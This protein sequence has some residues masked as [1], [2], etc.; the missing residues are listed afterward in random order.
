MPDPY[1][2]TV[3]KSELKRDA[4]M[5]KVVGKALKRR[6]RK[7][8][9]GRYSKVAALIPTVT[10]RP[11]TVLTNAQYGADA[12]GGTP[13][14]AADSS[15]GWEDTKSTKVTHTKYS[16]LQKEAKFGAMLKALMRRLGRAKPKSSGFGDRYVPGRGVPAEQ[17]LGYRTTP[18]RPPRPEP[19]GP[20]PM[21]GVKP[22]PVSPEGVIFK[23]NPFVHPP[24]SN[25]P[26][27]V[28]SIGPR[29]R[30]RGQS[31]WSWWERILKK[32]KEGLTDKPS[33]EYSKLLG[34]PQTT[35]LGIGDMAG[36]AAGAVKGTAKN[37]AVQMGAGGAAAAGTAAA[38]SDG[39]IRGM[40]AQHAPGASIM[41]L[42]Q[43]LFASKAQGA[44]PGQ[45][46][47]IGPGGQRL[48]KDQALQQLEPWF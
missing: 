2:T 11:P 16:S 38:L 42:L 13:P 12:W 9:R 6:K 3:A 35:Q 44:Q 7:K 21:S 36:R 39:G 15:N 26:R 47:I 25:M 1:E 31:P 41:Q 20:D 34:T 33:G 14:A 46:R 48:N 22:G 37:P 43:Q 40:L 30:T 27:P 45:S 8:P 32:R 24:S 4:A 18:T 5:D 23:N 19:W 28:G 17:T 29:G 10:G